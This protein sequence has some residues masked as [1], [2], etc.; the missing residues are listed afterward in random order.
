MSLR[1]NKKTID[2]I[3]ELEQEFFE[4]NIQRREELDGWYDLWA[5]KVGV[6]ISLEDFSQ[7]VLDRETIPYFAMNTCTKMV[8]H[9][10]H[11]T[12]DGACTMTWHLEWDAPQAAMFKGGVLWAIE[13]GLEVPDGILEAVK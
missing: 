13:N 5:G 1:L 12:E 7:G 11:I 9:E 2:K 8:D 3:H 4:E 10:T 6:D